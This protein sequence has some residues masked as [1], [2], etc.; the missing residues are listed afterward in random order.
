[1]KTTTITCDKCSEITGPR[2]AKQ[3]QITTSAYVNTSMDLCLKCHGELL[4]AFQMKRQEEPPG[5][6]CGALQDW[7]SDRINDELNSR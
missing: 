4:N 6:P 3:V 1:M 7:I 2:E 5:D